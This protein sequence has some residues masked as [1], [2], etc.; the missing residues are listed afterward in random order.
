MEESLNSWEY[1][2]GAWKNFDIF[3]IYNMIVY[4]NIN[5]VGNVMALYE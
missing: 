5:F 3:N 4:N 1:I 2:G